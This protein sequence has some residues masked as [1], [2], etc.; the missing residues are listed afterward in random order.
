MGESDSTTSPTAPRPRRVV[1]SALM[2]RYERL[3][4]QPVARSSRTPF[5]LFTD[6][7]GLTSETWEIRIVDPHVPGDSVR[8]SR[9][10][11]IRAGSALE[12]YDETLWID[13]RVQLRVDPSVVFDSWLAVAD[14]AMF[15]HSFRDHLIDEFSAVVEGG[16]DDPAVVYGQ[17]D[18]Y[19]ETAPE[20]L[21]AKPLWTGMIARRNNARVDRAMREWWEQ[22]ERF[23]RRDQLSAPLLYGAL[24]TALTVLAAESNHESVFH[25]WPP[26]SEALGRRQQ[27][28]QETDAEKPLILRVR[29]METHG[30]ALAK[31][32][33]GFNYQLTA[34]EQRVRYRDA[35]IRELQRTVELVREESDH[36][37]LI[38][39]DVQIGLQAA[40]IVKGHELAELQS[41][42]EAVSEGFANAL[43]LLTIAETRV[44]RQTKIIR[45][46]RRRLEQLQESNRRLQDGVRAGAHVLEATHASP[47]WK[48]ARVLAAPFRVLRFDSKQ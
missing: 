19:A 12:G 2:G 27:K 8:S 21:Q 25:E 1:Y 38:A 40:L 9:W 46:L 10:I 17:L 4:E 26:I 33:E 36:R 32:I 48:I 6:D 16:Y 43:R 22:V 42:H 28:T 15:E 41:R 20:L 7:P 5:V 29:E 35:S 30:D 44:S 13:N 47:T 39:R 45:R 23:S 18:H 14:T 3:Q 34:W 11:K 37:A 24:G 31:R